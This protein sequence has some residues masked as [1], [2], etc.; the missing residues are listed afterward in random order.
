MEVAF[1]NK[2]LIK[3]YETGH[4]RKLKLP[5][6][7]IEKYFATIQKIEA[8]TS[9]YDLSADIGLNFKRIKG[10]ENQ[11]SMR[12]SGKYRLQMEI[13]WQDEKQTIGTFNLTDITNHY[14]D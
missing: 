3:L 13:Q 14:G 7:I 6:H 5:D 2:E 8:A 12:L 9:I 11:W 4:A 1:A 10:Y